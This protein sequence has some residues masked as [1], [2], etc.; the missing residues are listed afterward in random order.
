MQ[1]NLRDLSPLWAFCQEKVNDWIHQEHKIRW[2]VDQD[3]RQSQALISGPDHGKERCVVSGMRLLTRHNTLRRYL[4]VMVLTEDPTC[5]FC[6]GRGIICT[7]TLSPWRER[8]QIFQVGYLAPKEIK[9]TT[10][11]EIL[12]FA[13][14]SRHGGMLWVT[15][16]E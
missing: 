2:C 8:F 6:E 1:R 3:L 5:R 11:G 13:L 9:E 7:P 10:L 16:S 14:E 12:S 15:T 4:H